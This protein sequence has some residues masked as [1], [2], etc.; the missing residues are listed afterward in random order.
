LRDYARATLETPIQKS[1]ARCE[2]YGDD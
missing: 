2:G 1:V